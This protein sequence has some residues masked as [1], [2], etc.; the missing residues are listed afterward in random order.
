VVDIIH[1]YRFHSNTHLTKSKASPLSLI[2]KLGPPWL[3][4]NSEQSREEEDRHVAINGIKSGM[5]GNE[6][7][8]V[9]V[10]DVGN[11]VV[12]MV[13]SLFRDMTEPLLAIPHIHFNNERESTWGVEVHSSKRLLAG[14]I[15]LCYHKKFIYDY[16][17]S[18]NNHAITVFD[19]KT[20]GGE[21]DDLGD[22]GEKRVLRGHEHNIPFI[23][24]NADGTILSSCSI[25]G[26]CRLVRFNSYLFF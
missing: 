23:S 6:R 2:H 14:K 11:V 24:I 7:V 19:L 8:V 3:K 1:V 4:S 5:I 22:A 9:S 10:D 15:N 12:F 20:R 25:D 18:A 13:D 21:R 17:V 26:T 16:I